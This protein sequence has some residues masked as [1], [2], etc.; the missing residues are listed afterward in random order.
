M[1]KIIDDIF[2]KHLPTLDLHG[3]DRDTASLLLK[4]FLLDNYHLINNQVVII[5]GIGTGIL[6]QMVHQTL[7]KDKLVLS[8]NLHRFNLGC[9]VVTLKK[10]ND[11]Y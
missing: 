2:I 7:K 4:D 11:N 6:K 10:K 5:H 1:K 9:T 3:L 8:F